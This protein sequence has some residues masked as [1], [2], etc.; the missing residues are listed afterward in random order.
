MQGQYIPQVD[1]YNSIEAF[2]RRV[3]NPHGDPALDAKLS[4]QPYAYRVGFAAVAPGASPQSVVN[5]AAN[6]DFVL[7]APRFHAVIDAAGVANHDNYPLIRVLM[8]D[9]GSQE[10]LMSEAVDLQSYFGHPLT[11]E[12]Q[13][14][15]PR[16]ISGR[17]GLSVQITNYS[18]IMTAPET[19][20][21]VELTLAG[22][23]VR[24]F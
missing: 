24:G 17:S 22:F 1:N 14:T 6:A 13:L 9:T 5:I 12:F 3:Y 11:A 16:I 19:Y 4:I 20:V 18:N 7:T 10:Q 15:Y 23:L 2:V 21:L 8:T